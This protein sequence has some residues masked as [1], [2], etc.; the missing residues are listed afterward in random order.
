[1]RRAWLKSAVMALAILIAIPASLAAAGQRGGATV[2]PSTTRKPERPADESDYYLELAR[3]AYRYEVFD[4]AEKYLVRA[5]ETQ[6]TPEK[7]CELHFYLGTLYFHNMDRQKDA[8]SVLEMAFEVAPTPQMQEE[9]LNQIMMM[10]QQGGMYAKAESVCRQLIAMREDFRARENYRRKLVN[11]IQMAKNSGEAI[12]EFEAVLAE[13]PENDDALSILGS[14]YT[15]V[16]PNPGRAVT[17]YE[18]LYKNHPDV[19]GLDLVLAN[20]YEANAQ[21]D[22]AAALFLSKIEGFPEKAA[23]GYQKVARIYSRAGDRE[24]ALKYAR[25]AVRVEEGTEAYAAQL[26]G[27]LM[28]LGFYDEA[29]EQYQQAIQLAEDPEKAQDHTLKCGRVKQL[30]GD[31]DAALK[32]F[33]KVAE[34][35]GRR[36]KERAKVLISRLKEKMEMEK[37]GHT[38][39]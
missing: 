12:E 34:E 32:L 2:P 39:Q 16:E 11:T 9:A 13:D 8:V 19:D 22:K 1:M 26:G 37:Q 31:Y 15:R 4:D 36:I 23:P 24:N 14:I 38:G 29:F 5:I 27:I 6:Q 3:A 21:T 20:A 17:C 28:G 7:F 33:E 25:K 18:K 35:G 30:A 10:C